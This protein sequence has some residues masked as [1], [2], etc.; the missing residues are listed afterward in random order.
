M[1]P[2]PTLVSTPESRGFLCAILL[3]SGSPRPI[4]V[5]GCSWANRALRQGDGVIQRLWF[6]NHLQRHHRTRSRM[7]GSMADETQSA[8]YPMHFVLPFTLLKHCGTLKIPHGGERGSKPLTASCS[9]TT[10]HAHRLS[11]GFRTQL[12]MLDVTRKTEV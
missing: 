8:C 5:T 6:Q 12:R 10:T 1:R 2:S 7:Y 4:A 9:R 11:A 3:S